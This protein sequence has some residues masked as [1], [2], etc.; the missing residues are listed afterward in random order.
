MIDVRYRVNG[1]VEENYVA[2]HCHRYSI[3]RHTDKGVWIDDYSGKQRFI[4]NG[5]HK[6]WAY[7]MEAEAWVS[8][9]KRK[10]RH[11]SILKAQLARA[12]RTLDET[13]VFVANG[14]WS[15]PE[16]DFSF[17]EAF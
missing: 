10:R 11:I 12:E 4:L 14:K 7:P 13:N 8:F 17:L 16:S 15:V 3:L 5:R 1:Y 9:I 2:V 6:Q